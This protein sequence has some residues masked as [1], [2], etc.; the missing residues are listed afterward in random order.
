MTERLP[1]REPPRQVAQG[2]KQRSARRLLRSAALEPARR[3]PD[4]TARRS[5]VPR[6]APRACPIMLLWLLDQLA[7]W[8]DALSAQAAAWEK[9]TFRAAAAA[10]ASFLMALL[11]G[12]R[13]IAWLRTRFREPIKTDSAQ[14]A[15]LHQGKAA[16]PT[17][18]GLFVVAALLASVLLLADCSNPML[19]AA[20][21]AALGLGSVGAIDDLV[22][23]RT[24]RSGL[25]ARW[26]LVLQIAAATP[27]AMLLY[28]ACSR[29]PAGLDLAVPLL[30]MALPL[31]WLFV[32]LAVLVI[33]AS[34]NAVNLAD[35]LDGLA[36]GCLVLA[37]GGMGVAV[38]AA[39]HRDLADY[40]GLAHLPHAGELTVLA[41]AMIGALLGFLWFN[42]HPAAVFLGDTGS[43]PLGGLLGVIAVAARQE[44]LLL[45]VGGVFVA[46]AA[47]VLLQ[48]GW[49]KWRRRR[50]LLCAPL[51]HHFQFK[52]WPESKIVVR[53]WIAGALCA[54]LGLASLKTNVRG[55]EDASAIGRPRNTDTELRAARAVVTPPS[56]NR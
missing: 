50:I 18:G 23:L 19:V 15:Q 27:P 52:G 5:A 43:L 40:L 47:S 12:A 7:P 46:E 38:Y 45:L 20:L 34:S 48:V 4:G 25:P 39:G 37:V 54:A 1:R 26:K 55:G 14:L 8:S 2:N 35:G 24:E 53:F 3:R 42:C 9:I 11:L 28:D 13:T 10:L 51:H 49:Y 32:P 31:G 21:V 17:M 6:S 33:V 41:G 30:D 56:A 44:L 29:T 22:K 36:G 16:T